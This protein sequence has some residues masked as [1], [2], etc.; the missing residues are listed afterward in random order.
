MILIFSLI[1]VYYKRP[2][3]GVVNGITKGKKKRSDRKL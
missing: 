2:G 3:K 1:K